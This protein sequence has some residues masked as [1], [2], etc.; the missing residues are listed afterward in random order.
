MPQQNNE[1][2]YLDELN[3]GR[4]KTQ[5]TKI[6]LEKNRA[7]DYANLSQKQRLSESQNLMQRNIALQQQTAIN[8]E[9][10]TANSENQIQPPYEEPESQHLSNLNQARAPQAQ[11]P[12]VPEKIAVKFPW[13]DFGLCLTNDI[14]DWLLV[15]SIPIAGDLIDILTSAKRWINKKVSKP[16]MAITT[17]VEIIPGGDLIPTYTIQVLWNYF[18]DK[19]NAEEQDKSTYQEYLMQ[20]QQINMQQ[21]FQQQQSE[22]YAETA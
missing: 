14:V 12:P 4:R 5:Q 1:N 9:Q 18:S 17:L 20:V 16:G 6:F 2:K 8:Q 22:E 10:E 13:L 21:E 7:K 19:K 11:L 15:G 3:Q